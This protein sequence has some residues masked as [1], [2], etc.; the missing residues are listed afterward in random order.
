MIREGDILL[1]DSCI[2]IHFKESNNFC[3][4]FKVEYRKQQDPRLLKTGRCVHS[5]TSVIALSPDGVTIAIACNHDISVYNTVNTE[6]EQII[7]EAHICKCF[8]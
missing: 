3:L 1:A 4:T 8:F 5:G 2:G 6:C 7:E